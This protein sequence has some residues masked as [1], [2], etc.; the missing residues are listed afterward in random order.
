MNEIAWQEFELA[1]YVIASPSSY[2]IWQK[3]WI[4]ENNMALWKQMKVLSENVVGR[5]HTLKANTENKLEN[6]LVFLNSQ[7]IGIKSGV[8][9]KCTIQFSFKSRKVKTPNRRIQT[10]NPTS[11][12]WPFFLEKNLALNSQHD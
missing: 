12:R 10:A 11:E 4:L 5:C 9:K 2:T 7:N 8:N 6:L 3:K 1:Y